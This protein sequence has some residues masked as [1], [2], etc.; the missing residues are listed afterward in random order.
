MLFLLFHL[1]NDRYA[2][3]TR[4]IV[5]VIPMIT[6]KRLPQAPAGLAG[7]FNYRGLPVPALDLSQLALGRPAQKRLSTR[8]IIVNRRDGSEADHLLGVIAERATE[9]LR[10]DPGDFVASGVN[11]AG[12]PYLGPVLA[13]TS[14]LIQWVDVDKMLTPA[15]RALFDQ[16]PVESS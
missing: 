15:M 13:D 9:T 16:L 10:R 5:E 2:L 11:D 14:G 8:I 12:A 6:L 3:D 1:G 4:Q 7:L